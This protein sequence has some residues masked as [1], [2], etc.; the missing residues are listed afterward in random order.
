MVGNQLTRLI[1]II[2]PV[3]KI[4]QK[5]SI[6]FVKIHFD[7]LDPDLICIYQKLSE[8]FIEKHFDNFDR[9]NINY[10]FRYQN[11]SEKF[12]EKYF[13]KLIPIFKE[14]KISKQSKNYDIYQNICRQIIN[15]RNR[16][17]KLNFNVEFV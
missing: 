2:F 11:L 6:K 17:K 16:Y 14:N 12:I 1:G 3:L 15:N 9:L 13:D 7:K 5:L 4:Y 10:I 8:N